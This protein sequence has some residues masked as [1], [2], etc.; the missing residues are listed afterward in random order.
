MVISISCQANK[1]S[2]HKN[3]KQLYQSL[4]MQ[5]S[6]L[7]L[8]LVST[9]TAMVDSTRCNS[10]PKYRVLQ[11]ATG[12]SS[13]LYPC[14]KAI[15]NAFCVKTISR[16][17]RTTSQTARRFC[18]KCMSKPST[19]RKLVGGFKNAGSPSVSYEIY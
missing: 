2:N 9:T 10:I 4:T 15:L 14:E 11:L 7:L 19:L 8:V 12:H 5:F 1:Q 18:A 16:R 6:T 17:A 3:H 13:Q